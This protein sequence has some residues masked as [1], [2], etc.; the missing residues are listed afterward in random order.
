MIVLLDSLLK[1][2]IT[3]ET[4]FADIKYFP[5]ILLLKN[6]NTFLIFNRLE[7]IIA[8]IVRKVDIVPKRYAGIFNDDYL[9]PKFF[10]ITQYS[11]YTLVNVSVFIDNYSAAHFDNSIA[12]CR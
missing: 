2:L 10:F 9:D 4:G 6:V 11:E 5:R 7:A 12:H 3:F 1:A 8:E